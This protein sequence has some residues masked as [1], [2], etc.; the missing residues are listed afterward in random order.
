MD[1]FEVAATSSKV[2]SDHVLGLGIPLSGRVFQMKTLVQ[3]EGLQR[4]R[5]TYLISLFEYADEGK[6]G[7]KYERDGRIGG[8]SPRQTAGVMVIEPELQKAPFSYPKKDGTYTRID[9]S[10][11]HARVT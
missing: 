1:A 9:L 11:V 6:D 4:K 10:D 2:K 8:E 5:N 7:N 3:I